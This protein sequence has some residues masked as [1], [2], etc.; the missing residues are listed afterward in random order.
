MAPHSRKLKTILFTLGT[1][2]SFNCQIRSWNINNGTDDGERFYT[3]CPDGEFFEEAEPEYTLELSFFAD[4]RSDGISEFL[5]LNDQQVADF[6]LEHHPDI[7]GEHVKWTGKVKV[8]HPSVG[9][10]ARTTEVTEVTLPI[11]GKPAFERVVA[12]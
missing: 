9:G 4:W 7:S 11:L 6:V 2:T 10:D 12:T 1:N 5:V 8:K 3:F